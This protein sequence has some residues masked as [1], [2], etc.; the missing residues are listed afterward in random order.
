MD[1]W[2]RQPELFR[3][4]VGAVPIVLV[5]VLAQQVFGEGG[6]VPRA[7][8]IVVV[9]WSAL[10]VRRRWPRAAFAAA[11]GVVAIATTG[12]EFLVVVSY[13]LVA[14]DRRAQP[15]AVGALSAVALVIGYL[16]YWPAVVLDQIAGD[17]I[18]IAAIAVLPPVIGLMVRTS[19]DKTAELRERNAELVAMRERE[20]RHAVEAERF[21]IARELH[22][23]VAHHVSAMTVRARAGHHVAER[24]P[25][26]AR[27]ALAWIAEAGTEALTAMGA[28]VGTL[29]GQD[30]TDGA[31]AADDLSPQPS[32]DD[33][34]ALLERFR[35][36]GLVVHEDL[37]AAPTVVSPTLGLNAYRIVQ[38]G[39]TNAL[40]HGAAERA[41]V[42]V[43]CADGL[44]HVRVDDNGRGL[45]DGGVPAG[46][47][48]VGVAERAALHDGTSAFGPGPRGGCRL[49]ASLAL[50]DGPRSRD[51][52]DTPVATP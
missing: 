13:T 37:E 28:L 47:G 35:R 30:A 49:E 51:A 7:V 11:L 2:R 18:L 43:W 26:A 9:M 16:Q 3:D 21:R 44:L 5:F 8:A 6:S 41:W 29:R 48:L 24:D 25:A 19:R 36:T 22:D 42:R 23:V 27:D 1:W 32:L 40:R 34:P 50:G 20:A 31:A 17:L 15:A 39:L 12:L 52:T 4:A 10:T 38:E 33:L 14:H 45:P 46:H